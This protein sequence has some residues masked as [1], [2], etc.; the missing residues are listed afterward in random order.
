FF[1]SLFSNTQS[2]PLMLDYLSMLLYFCCH[3]EPAQGFTRALSLMIGHTLHY[4]HTSPL[5]Q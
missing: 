4:K 1:F 2:S 3:P 5:T